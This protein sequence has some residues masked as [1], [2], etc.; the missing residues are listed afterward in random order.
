MANNLAQHMLEVGVT[1]M[2]KHDD[3]GSILFSN[4]CAA[5]FVLGTETHDRLGDIDGGRCT[6]CG[7]DADVDPLCYTTPDIEIEAS[8]EADGDDEAM[9]QFDAALDVED[10][11]AEPHEYA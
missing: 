3:R 9:N 6:S 11:E 5:P 2:S 7:A 1:G 8:L 4:C 10:W